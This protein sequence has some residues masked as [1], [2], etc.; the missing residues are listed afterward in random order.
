MLGGFGEKQLRIKQLG[1]EGRS[2]NKS[3]FK[4][5]GFYLRQAVE[6][7]GALSSS[8]HSLTQAAG[9]APVQLQSNTSGLSTQQM[10]DI[11]WAVTPGG[12]KLQHPIS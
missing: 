4:R 8:Q 7:H 11:L 6:E 9:P 5:T 10:S 1:D 3:H 2:F 12:T